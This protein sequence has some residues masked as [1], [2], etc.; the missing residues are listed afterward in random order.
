MDTTIA[1]VVPLRDARALGSEPVGGKAAKLSDL[2]AL[3]YPV[4]RGF[5]I[6]TETYRRFVQQACSS[7]NRE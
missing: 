2:I 5:C 4:P 1:L 6:T 7:G 3:E